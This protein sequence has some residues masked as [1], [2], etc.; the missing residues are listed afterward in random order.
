MHRH[1]DE[2]VVSAYGSNRKK[3]YSRFCRSSRVRENCKVESAPKFL[4]PQELLLEVYHL[5]W[6]QFTSF[7]SRRPTS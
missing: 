7:Y 1:L 3:E 5:F 4:T 6:K 2:V